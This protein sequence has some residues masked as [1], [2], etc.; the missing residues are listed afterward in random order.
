MLIEHDHNS[1]STSPQI[2]RGFSDVERF[3]RNVCSDVLL[4]R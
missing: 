2:R 4:A 1:K 3:E